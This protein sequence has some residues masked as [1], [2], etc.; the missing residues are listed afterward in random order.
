MYFAFYRVFADRDENVVL[1]NLFTFINALRV[2]NAWLTNRD[3]S[4]FIRQMM[5]RSVSA[6]QV[7]SNSP[8]SDKST[9]RYNPDQHRHLHRRENL[10]IHYNTVFICAI[11]YDQELWRMKINNKSIGNT[12]IP[13]SKVFHSH[14]V[15][16]RCICN[17][18]AN[19]C[20]LCPVMEVYPDQVWLPWSVPEKSG[21]IMVIYLTRTSYIVP[22]VS[23]SLMK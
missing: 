7:D 1:N 12:R 15:K 19:S 4:S 13:L 3:V 18:N 10:K 11:N 2:Y 22:L 21:T 6:V 17:S 20:E 16:Y 8:S 5:G 23:N 14:T 9:R